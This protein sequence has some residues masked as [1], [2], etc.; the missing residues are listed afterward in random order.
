[1]ADKSVGYF[2]KIAY[3]Q[4]YYEGSWF[5]NRGL[6]TKISFASC[7][8]NVNRIEWATFIEMPTARHVLQNILDQSVQ[9]SN[10]EK[11]KQ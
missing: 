9:R 5:L 2:L 11:K 6:G 8:G 7:D 1:M 3:D 4:K 10:N